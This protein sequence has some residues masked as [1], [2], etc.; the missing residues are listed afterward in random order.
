[1]NIMN[2]GG[3]HD[4]GE[5]RLQIGMSKN[6]GFVIEYDTTLNMITLKDATSGATLPI[7]A[8]SASPFTFCGQ[9]ST[10]TDLTN[11]VTAGTITPAN[12]DAYSIKSAGGT[13][14]NGTTISA[15][16]IVAYGNDNKW[17]IIGNGNS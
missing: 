13:D 1:M 10:Y 11:A 3:V 6:K 4:N 9:Y 7:L 5:P 17:Y 12:G 16:D 14:G 15:L 8:P 2:I